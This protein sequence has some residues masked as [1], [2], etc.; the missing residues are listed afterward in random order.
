MLVEWLSADNNL[1][2][3]S[4]RPLVMIRKTSDGSRSPE[5]TKDAYGLG[6]PVRDLASAG[7]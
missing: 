3:C 1:A 4:M 5:G 2:K 7:P 6:Q